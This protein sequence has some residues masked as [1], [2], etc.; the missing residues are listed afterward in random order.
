MILSLQA[1]LYNFVLICIFSIVV[2]VI[3]LLNLPSKNL[4]L[5]LINFLENV[6]ISYKVYAI[7]KS[8]SKRLLSLYGFVS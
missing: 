2:S 1:L 5:I 8:E 3:R 4:R 6:I 7:N